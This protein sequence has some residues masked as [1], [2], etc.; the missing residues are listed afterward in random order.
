MLYIDPSNRDKA[1][2]RYPHGPARITLGEDPDARPI[3]ELKVG[4]DTLLVATAQDRLYLE[5]YA[6]LK[7]WE[8]SG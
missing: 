2:R 3:Y 1:V 6:L 5:N 4:E 7:G 8:I